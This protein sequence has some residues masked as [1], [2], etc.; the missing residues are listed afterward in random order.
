MDKP[1]YITMKDPE[2]LKMHCI[3]K[4]RT[5]KPEI[6]GGYY[7]YP[8][9][10]SD[11]EITVKYIDEDLIVRKMEKQVS[12]IPDILVNTKYS[13][14]LHY[15]RFRVIEGSMYHY[16]NINKEYRDILYY[17]SNGLLGSALAEALKYTG[18]NT[19]FSRVVDIANDIIHI[20]LKY[21]DMSIVNQGNFYETFS[22][23]PPISKLP[24]QNIIWVD[25]IDICRYNDNNQYFD[26]INV[27]FYMITAVK[28]RKEFIKKNM[29]YLTEVAKYK[30]CNDKRFTKYGVPFNFLKLDRVHITRDSAV[31]FT[32][33]LKELKENDDNAQEQ[34]ENGK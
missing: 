23:A 31:I 34:I 22:S 27:E 11:P 20:N 26:F 13:A 8:Y 2:E 3:S 17:Q 29:K 32:Y 7:G 25:K 19:A 15:I 21:K 10:D 33:S 16:V 12:R 28:Q 4:S 14:S 5:I 1:Q 6:W 24:I 9:W 18:V 30:L